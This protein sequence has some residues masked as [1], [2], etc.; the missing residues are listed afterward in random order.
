MNFC[1]TFLHSSIVT[2]F[3]YCVLWVHFDGHSLYT[4]VSIKVE[5]MFKERFKIKL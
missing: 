3:C 1:K 2:M 4:M 5:V